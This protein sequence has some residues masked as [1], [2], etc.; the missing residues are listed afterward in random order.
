MV[1]AREAFIP[2]GIPA[3]SAFTDGP[4]VILLKEHT[5]MQAETSIAPE[6]QG[7]FK[8]P[9]DR[10]VLRRHHLVAPRRGLPG[11][12]R[13]EQAAD[14]QAPEEVELKAAAHLSA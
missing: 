13:E 9:G 5:L 6:L 11:K 7:S 2:V 14:G 1:R 3:R 8:R 12:D 10:V 4:E